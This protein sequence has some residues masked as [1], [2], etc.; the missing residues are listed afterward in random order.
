MNN[1]IILAP[2][3]LF[4]T[5]WETFMFKGFELSGFCDFFL[6][7]AVELSEKL[8]PSV[9]LNLKVELALIGL[10]TTTAVFSGRYDLGATAPF[11]SLNLGALY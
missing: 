6:P 3:S 1:D 11:F 2:Q 10:F 5:L 4:F 7:E 9:G 8:E